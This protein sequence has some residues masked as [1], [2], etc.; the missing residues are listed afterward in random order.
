M[1]RAVIEKYI[2]HHRDITHGPAQ[3]EIKLR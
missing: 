1:T 3:L 2:A